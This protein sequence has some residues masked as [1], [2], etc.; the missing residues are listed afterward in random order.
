MVQNIIDL[1]ATTAARIETLIHSDAV[2]LSDFP[3]SLQLSSYSCGTH[4][5]YTILKYFNKYCTYKSIERMLRTDVDGTDVSDIKRV[6]K[7]YGLSC[8]TL[9]KPGVRD[10]MTAIDDDC[11]VLISLY[12]SEH[13]SVVYG[14]SSGHIW[15]SNPS[16]NVLTGYGSI[17]CAITKSEFRNIW[18]KWAV[19]I[20]E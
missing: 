13:Y 3:R 12:D 11:P 14:Y 2:I 17:R 16:L 5:V 1:I 19:V 8:R 10:L 20:S 18:D 6:L 15:V 7:R 4:S 9:R